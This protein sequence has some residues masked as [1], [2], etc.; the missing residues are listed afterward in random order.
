MTRDEYVAM[1]K[2]AFISIAKQKAMESLLGAFT[3]LSWPI[4][5][6]IA[7]WIVSIIM[8]SAVEAAEMQ[9][10]FLYI[11]MRVGKQSEDWEGAAYANYQAQ[12]YGTAEEKAV[13]AQRLREAHVR[14]VSFSS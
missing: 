8:T 7:S 13:A 6:P 11:D 10:F 4:L 1:V 14:F 3:F 5:K 9:A 2:S 12:L